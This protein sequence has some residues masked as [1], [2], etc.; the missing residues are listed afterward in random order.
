MHAW[1]ALKPADIIQAARALRELVA[2]AKA[3]NQAEPA[4]PT[5]ESPD[6]RV[7]TG[8]SAAAE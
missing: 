1:A 3:D 7:L 8:E 2:G 5:D 6:E 4:V